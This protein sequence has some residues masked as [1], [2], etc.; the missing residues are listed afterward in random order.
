MFAVYNYKTD[1]LNK[2]IVI[3][4][5]LLFISGLIDC[6]SPGNIYRAQ[7]EVMK[8][9][10]NIYIDQLIT[11]LLAIFRGLLILPFLIWSFKSTTRNQT[12]T[13]MQKTAIKTALILTF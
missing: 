8:F 5:L 9:G 13:N 3:M 1:H 11:I 10:F 12:L 2:N 7:E 6:L 4:L